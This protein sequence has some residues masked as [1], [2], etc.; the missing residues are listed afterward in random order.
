MTGFDALARESDERLREMARA[1]ADRARATVTAA[2]DGGF[3]EVLV[4][5]T[6]VLLDVRL[7]AARLRSV[8]AARLAE[9]V[10]DAIRRAERELSAPPAEVAR[11]RRGRRPSPD[12]PEELFTGLADEHRRR[13]ARERVSCCPHCGGALPV[14][15]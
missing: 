8:P 15:D 14:Q 2:I 13:A 4:G 12:E 6:G 3:G 1:A 10:A 5:G 7:E 11:P 9:A